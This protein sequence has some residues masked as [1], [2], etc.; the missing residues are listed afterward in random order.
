M[1]SIE[2]VANGEI[3]IFLVPE[4]VIDEYALEQ[5]SKQSIEIVYH[6]KQI[7]VLDK[8]F[9]KGAIIQ[10]KKRIENTGPGETSV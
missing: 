8:Q 6:N 9:S 7:Q 2:V 10:V 4:T 3:K 1:K 5:L